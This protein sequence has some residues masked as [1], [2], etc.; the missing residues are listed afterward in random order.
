[1]LITKSRDFFE[2]SLLEDISLIPTN[3]IPSSLE[4]M[5][6]ND[7]IFSHSSLL[8]IFS[9]ANLPGLKLKLQHH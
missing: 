3:S 6:S 8:I 4:I 7:D 9:V 1:M 5:L 2:K